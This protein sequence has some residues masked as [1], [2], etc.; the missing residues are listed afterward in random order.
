MFLN[1]GIHPAPPAEGMSVSWKDDEGQPAFRVL[2]LTD[3][4]HAFFPPGRDTA[5][6]EAVFDPSD[7]ASERL[8]CVRGEAACGFDRLIGWLDAAREASESSLAVVTV[9]EPLDAWSEESPFPASVRRVGPGIEHARHGNAAEQVREMLAD[10]GEGA[11]LLCVHVP[12][13]NAGTTSDLSKILNAWAAEPRGG[14]VRRVL[15]LTHDDLFASARRVAPHALLRMPSLNLG[16]IAALTSGNRDVARACLEW[17]G[18]QPLL[19]TTYLAARAE[20]PA[21]ASPGGLKEFEADLMERPPLAM[22]EWMADL[23]G[24]LVANPAIRLTVSSFVRDD[25]L[26]EH[27]LRS[28][29]LP[30]VVSGWLTKCRLRDGEIRWGFSSARRHFGRQV[31]TSPKTHLR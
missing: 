18:G 28:E 24:I 17:S 2:R 22:R 23:A 16:D 1:S 21:T 31:L 13:A 7:A 14:T 30:L 8:V 19:A 25:V 4:Q 12:F 11:P 9:T 20:L 3:G 15:L 29:M 10:T 27:A 5:L 26:P 6:T